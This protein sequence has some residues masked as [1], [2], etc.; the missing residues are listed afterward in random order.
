MKIECPFCSFHTRINPTNPNR[1]DEI[2]KR[3]DFLRH[4]LQFECPINFVGYAE[5]YLCES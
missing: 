2:R 4:H 3:A 5:D 1:A